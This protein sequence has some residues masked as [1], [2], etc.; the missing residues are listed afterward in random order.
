MAKQHVIYVDFA[1]NGAGCL[2]IFD[3]DQENKPGNS[4]TTE[5][6]FAE[7]KVVKVSDTVQWSS[8]VNTNVLTISFP[9]GSPFAA[10][11]LSQ[12]GSSLVTSGAVNGNDKTR[13]KYDIELLNPTS[14]QVA[15][16]DPQIIIDNQGLGGRRRKR[17]AK[18][19]KR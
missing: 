15:Y 3:D 17:P 19:G 9:L 14:G 5:K 10:P 18:K 2:Q 1:A 11:E 12:N 7:R 13:Y 6:G 4:S 8:I 16:E